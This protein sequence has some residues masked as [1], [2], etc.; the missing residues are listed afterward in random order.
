MRRSSGPKRSGAR[1]AL[2]LAGV[3][4]LVACEGKQGAQGPQGPDGITGLDGV[5]GTQGPAGALGSI[6]PGGPTGAS[7]ATGATGATGSTGSTGPGGDAGS[8]TGS[9]VVHVVDGDCGADLVG[10][11]VVA[12]PGN[13]TG[14]TDASGRV[15]FAALPVGVYHFTVTAPSLRLLGNAMVSGV[16]ATS[17]GPALAVRAAVAVSVDLPLRRLDMDQLNLVTLHNSTKPVY[18]Q[19]NCETCHGLRTGE[20]SADPLKAPYHAKH[21]QFGCVFCHAAVDLAHSSG[22]NIRKQVAVSKCKGC[23]SQ[24]PTKIC[25]IPVCP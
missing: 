11:T 12:V 22:A 21:A 9:V 4:G 14:L 20:L 10:A 1:A 19:A 18:T 15:S 13:D 7:G 5:P 25:T 3:L 8:S 2:L 17:T 24:Y 6:G 23:H 16:D